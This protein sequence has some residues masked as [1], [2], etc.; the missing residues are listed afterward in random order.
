M[1]NPEPHNQRRGLVAIDAA[2]ALI[3]ILLVVQMWLLERHARDVSGR[4]YRRGV[5]AADFFQRSTD[6]IALANGR[7]LPQGRD[8][9]KASWKAVHAPGGCR[10][11]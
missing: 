11:C 3:V 5:P 10:A 8:E 2:M 7:H 4:P 6:W 9:S 1:P